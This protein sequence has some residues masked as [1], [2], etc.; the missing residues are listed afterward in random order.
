MMWDDVEVTRLPFVLAQ[1]AHSECAGYPLLLEVQRVMMR[2]VK[3]SPATSA[4]WREGKPKMY[5][6]VTG[7]R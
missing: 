5:E 6:L 4:Y 2:A 1:R 7:S 3:G